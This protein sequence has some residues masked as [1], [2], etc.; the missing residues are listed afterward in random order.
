MLASGAEP[1]SRLWSFQSSQSFS[2]LFLLRFSR[3][4][5]RRIAGDVAILEGN[6]RLDI[7]LP[8]AMSG[9]KEKRRMSTKPTAKSM[10]V[11]SCDA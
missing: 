7:S 9:D 3:I 6:V 1:W 11:S 8:E 4:V 5:R 10:P 2:N